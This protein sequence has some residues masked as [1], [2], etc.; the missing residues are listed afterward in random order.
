MISGWLSSYC[1]MIIC[2]GIITAVGTQHHRLIRLAQKHLTSQT[3]NVLALIVH[4][5]GFYLQTLTAS[6]FRKEFI[7]LIRCCWHQH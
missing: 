1:H 2:Y 4:S 6:V 3:L 7:K 5:S